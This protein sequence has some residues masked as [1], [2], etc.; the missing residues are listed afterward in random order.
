VG[1]EY[2]EDVVLG[3]AT[4]RLFQYARNAIALYACN[5][6]LQSMIERLTFFRSIRK[7]GNCHTQKIKLL[8]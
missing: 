1:F 2:E 5:P 8:E 4:E 6:Y 3:Q 7:G